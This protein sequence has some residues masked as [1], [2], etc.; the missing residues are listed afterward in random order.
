MP[1]GSVNLILHRSY[2]L[3]D[4][5]ELAVLA[6]AVPVLGLNRGLK[7]SPL[8][9]K[10]PDLLA[11]GLSLGSRVLLFLMQALQLQIQRGD[12]LGEESLLVLRL[13]D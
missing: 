4:P 12:L 3:V 6:R 11:E 13:S 1:Q 2:L 7:L 10:G 8:F 5:F 9:F